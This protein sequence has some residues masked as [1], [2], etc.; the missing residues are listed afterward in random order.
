MACHLQGQC[1]VLRLYNVQ[2]G[3]HHHKVC[4]DGGTK[5]FT[6]YYLKRGMIACIYINCLEEFA[7]GMGD[8]QFGRGAKVRR[9]F[10]ITNF[11]AT[12]AS[13]L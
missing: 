2:D 5:V 9:S 7:K 10:K 4:N 1:L 12:H 11:F 6:L 13:A 8:D 3:V